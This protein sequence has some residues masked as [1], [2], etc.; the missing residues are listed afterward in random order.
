MF[1]AKGSNK[2]RSSIKPTGLRIFKPNFL[3]PTFSYS[4]IRT[5]VSC[6][7]IYV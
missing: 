2:A 5:S 1:T 4:G 3:N 7:S 6:Q